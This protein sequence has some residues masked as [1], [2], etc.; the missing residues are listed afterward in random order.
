MKKLAKL[1][2]IFALV[3]VMGFLM[4]ACENDLV[5]NGDNNWVASNGPWPEAWV[6]SSPSSSFWSNTGSILTGHFLQVSDS[7]GWIYFD[8][9]SSGTHYKITS[10]TLNK[11]GIKVRELTS[12]FNVIGNEI[13]LCTSWTFQNNRLTLRGTTGVFTVFEG[14]ALYLL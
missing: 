11:Q 1:V 9:A 13:T 12:D 7:F 10:M 14:R 4:T 6:P 2:G 8:G 3:A 5:N